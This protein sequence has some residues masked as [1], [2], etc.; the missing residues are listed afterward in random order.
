M[1]QLA[2][3][4][5]V[6]VVVSV[7]WAPSVHGRHSEMSRARAFSVLLVAHRRQLAVDTALGILAFMMPALCLS[8]ADTWALEDSGVD[9]ARLLA[10]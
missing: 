7:S 9:V 3:P 1:Q 4:S 6:C 2:Y 10:E 8:V 5:D